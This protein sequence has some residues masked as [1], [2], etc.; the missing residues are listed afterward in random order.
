[1]M[2]FTGKGDDGRTGWLGKGRLPKYD[3]RI[4]ALGTLDEATA[5]LGISRSL[6]EELPEAALLLEAQRNLYS[7][8][9]EVATDP[10]K[11]TKVQKILPETIQTL[12][13]HIQTLGAK[14]EMPQG[15]ILPGDSQ[16]SASL[17]LSR[18]IVRRAERRVVELFDRG[19]VSNP[20]LGIYLNRLSSFC[21]VLEIYTLQVGGKDHPTMAKGEDR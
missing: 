18:A 7:L 21:F 11:A 6:M 19:L 13:E 15:F 1:M 16:P 17:A 5:A 8:M 3:A 12:E 14:V 20:L 2:F 9:A 10:E 4:E